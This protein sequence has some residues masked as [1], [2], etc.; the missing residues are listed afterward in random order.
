MGFGAYK[1]RVGY[2][3]WEKDITRIDTASRLL[4]NNRLMVDAIMGTLKDKWTLEE[5][6]QK[7]KEMESKISSKSKKSIKYR[8]GRKGE[9]TTKKTQKNT[10]NCTKKHPPM[11]SHERGFRILK[12]IRVG[13]RARWAPR[14]S[15]PRFWHHFGGILDR[16]CKDFWYN[17]GSVFL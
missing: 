5:A 8:S 7:T 3:T 14:P 13:F 11:V 15:K 10:T 1:M 12:C 4:Q 2:Q 16:F 17:F 6:L 9:K